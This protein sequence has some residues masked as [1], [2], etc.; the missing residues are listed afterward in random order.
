[1]TYLRCHWI[2]FPLRLRLLS[3]H[4]RAVPP[5]GLPLPT[6][7]AGWHILSAQTATSEEKE[8]VSLWIFKC[9]LCGRWGVMLDLGFLSCFHEHGFVVFTQAHLILFCASLHVTDLAFLQI[10]GLWQHYNEQV[11]APS[12]WQHLLT[13]CLCVTFW[14]F[15]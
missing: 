4:G 11:L 6:C 14:S 10:Q 12:F 2:G 3:A 5:H 1:M 15:S 13:S 9:F 7:L 8:K